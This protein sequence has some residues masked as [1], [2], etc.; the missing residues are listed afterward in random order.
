MSLNF[1]SKPGQKGRKEL[2]NLVTK[3]DISSPEAVVTSVLAPHTVES[4]HVEH[5]EKKPL[6]IK[7]GDKEFYGNFLSK[8]IMLEILEKNRLDYEV[9]VNA[10]KWFD[11]EKDCLNGDDVVKV[12]E[13][14]RLLENSRATVQFHQPQRFSVSKS[15]FFFLISCLK[16]HF[17]IF[18]LHI[19]FCKGGLPFSTI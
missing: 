4:F 16:S 5:W 9:D 17:H 7:R 10:W 15:K 2:E 11:G 3:L 6:Y 12:A 1:N 8:D 19:Q 13:V 14:K 18:I